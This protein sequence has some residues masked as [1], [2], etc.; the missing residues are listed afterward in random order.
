MSQNEDEAY[1]S[2]M[3]AAERS[4]ALGEPESRIKRDKQQRAARWLDSSRAAERSSA[5]AEES[6]QAEESS[7][8]EGGKRFKREERRSSTAATEQRTEVV[9]SYHLCDSSWAKP[10]GLLSLCPEQFPLGDV[11]ALIET[12]TIELAKTIQYGRGTVTST[13]TA[14]PTAWTIIEKP[15]TSRTT[16]SPTTWITVEKPTTST[17]TISPTSWTTTEVPVTQT[18]T[19]IISEYVTTLVKET[20]LTQTIYSPVVTVTKVPITETVTLSSTLTEVEVVT[21]TLTSTAH[22]TAFDGQGYTRLYG[23]SGATACPPAGLRGQFQIWQN[24]LPVALVVSCVFLISLFYILCWDCCVG[25]CG[26]MRRAYI[27]LYTNNSD[28]DTDNIFAVDD[29]DEADN[30]NKAAEKGD[31]DNNSNDADNN[32]DAGNDAGTD[33]DTETDSN[34]DTGPKDRSSSPGSG[35]TNQGSK[36]SGGFALPSVGKPTFVGVPSAFTEAAPSNSL[37]PRPGKYPIQ[38]T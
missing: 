10:L 6:R 3:S 22:V 38:E 24:D 23:G 30:N 16:T 32:N 13:R 36:A 1:D 18:V 34:N 4:R 15:V 37:Y 12:Y 9:R 28:G 33:T 19:S 2:I 7:R 21:E 35:K 5:Q 17:K 14:R 27:E 31:A 8:A 29:I 11:S 25:C 26:L 20:G